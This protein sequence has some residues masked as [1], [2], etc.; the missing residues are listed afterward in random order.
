MT[1]G[2]SD[3]EFSELTILAVDDE[4]FARSMIVRVLE[5]LGVGRVLT[6]EDGAAALG[7]LEVAEPP[8]D[9]VISDIEMPEMNGYEFVRRLRYGALPA[10]KNLPVLMLTGR[11]TDKNVR[12][13]RIHKISGFIVKPPSAEG[14]KDQI[15]RA[16]G[17]A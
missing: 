5:T 9:L 4:A 14:L 16:L 11:D 1:D 15:R 17:D 6:A 2:Q 10:Y 13:A 3:V 12:G 7:V 8:V